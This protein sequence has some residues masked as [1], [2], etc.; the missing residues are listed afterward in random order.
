M[1]P[2]RVISVIRG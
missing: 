2:I 1:L